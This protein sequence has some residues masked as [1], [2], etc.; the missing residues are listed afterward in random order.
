MNHPDQKPAGPE[1]EAENTESAHASPCA[2]SP[3]S[4]PAAEPAAAPRPSIL[5]K[6]PPEPDSAERPSILKKQPP[7]PEPAAERPSILKKRPPEPEPA[8]AEAAA[9]PGAEQ[10]AREA[11]EPAAEIEQL[12]EEAAAM[13]DQLLRAL[14]ELENTRRRAER[15]RQDIAKY[16]ITDF[17]R[18]LLSPADNLR[19]ALDAVPADAIGQD[20]V[21]TNLSEGVEATERELL[22]AF[23]KFGIKRIESL[24][25]KFD[26]NF[27][28]AMF[29][30]PDSGKP[31]G[32]IVQV[33]QDGYVIHDRLL[34]PALVGVAKA[35]PAQKV[36]TTA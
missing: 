13:K 24:D 21:L 11:A 22:S 23:E 32:T 33:V 10:P 9:E 20:A 30:V 2:P 4:E 28:Q 31:A 18:D 34:R 35:E 3:E 8:A 27:H 5:K 25:Q 36:D 6:K 12:R 16:A 26:P 14:A 17:A 15:D 19:R 29:E 1:P 7:E